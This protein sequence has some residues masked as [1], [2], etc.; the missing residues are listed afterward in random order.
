MT[1][2]IVTWGHPHGI[3]LALPVDADYTVPVAPVDPFELAPDGT[4]VEDCFPWVFGSRPSLSPESTPDA[5][6]V[7]IHKN[8]EQYEWWSFDPISIY[9]DFDASRY[10]GDTGW[11]L[12]DTAVLWLHRR[13]HSGESLSVEG[14]RIEAKDGSRVRWQHTNHMFALKHGGVMLQFDPRFPGDYGASTGARRSSAGKNST[15]QQRASQ[16]CST[17]ALRLTWCRS[18]LSPTSSAP[19]QLTP[20]PPNHREKI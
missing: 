13:F 12:S 1:T 10:P 19:D 3:R 16:T 14:E 8:V 6:T 15:R 4:V 9:H 5:G 17:G 20:N 18:P 2:A 11:Y 7:C